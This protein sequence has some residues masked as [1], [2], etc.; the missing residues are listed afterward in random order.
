[1]GCDDEFNFELQ[2]RVWVG[3]LEETSPGGLKIPGC[4]EKGGLGSQGVHGSCK[5]AN[6]KE[7]EGSRM[8][9]VFK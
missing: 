7:R 4:V 1:M 2:L 9:R 8:Q 5:A 6:S 3:Q